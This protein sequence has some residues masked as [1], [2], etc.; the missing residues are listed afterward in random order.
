MKVYKKGRKL[1]VNDGDIY[2]LSLNYKEKYTIV[3]EHIHGRTQSGEYKICSEWKYVREAKIEEE[4]LFME[5]TKNKCVVLLK[6]KIKS[7]WNIS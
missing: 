5:L 3:C 4:L 6:D 2:C 7:E 1:Y